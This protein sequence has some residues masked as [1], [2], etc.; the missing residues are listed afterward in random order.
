MDLN[1]TIVWSRDMKAAS[2]FVADILG[3]PEPKGFGHFL[4]VEMDNGVSLDFS[5]Y[6]HTTGG[7]HYAFLIS[8]AEFDQVF[9]RLKARD[10]DYWADPGR[11]KLREINHHD[12]GRGMYFWDLDR[13][14]L[15]VITRPY[16]SAV[17]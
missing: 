8:E 13:N 4:V 2:K 16:G 3:R 5:D 12:G 9:D 17:V 1:H 11:E 7:Q 14:L 15:E 10:L 6:G